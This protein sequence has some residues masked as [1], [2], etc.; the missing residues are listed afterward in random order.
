MKVQLGSE[1]SVTKK[2]ASAYGVVMGEGATLS[3]ATFSVPRLPAHGEYTVHKTGLKAPS[4]TLSFKLHVTE[5]M[6]S[7]LW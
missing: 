4:F 5:N 7:A 2:L 3:E 6:A 1:L